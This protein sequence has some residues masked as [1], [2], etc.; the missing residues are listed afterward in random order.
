[1]PLMALYTNTNTHFG[2][3]GTDIGVVLQSLCTDGTL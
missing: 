3:F 1:M 2:L